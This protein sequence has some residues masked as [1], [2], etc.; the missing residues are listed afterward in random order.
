MSER[1]KMRVYDYVNRPYAEVRSALEADALNVFRNA[2][3]VASHR[4]NTLA[5]ELHVNI[6]GIEVG[7]DIK[8]KINSIETLPATA[9]APETTR[10]ELEWEAANM[11]RLFPFMKAELNVYPLTRSETQLDLNGNYQ[12]PLG[13][14]GSVLDAAVGHRIAEATVQQ[15]IKDVAAFLRA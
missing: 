9:T 7:T 5:S 2:T 6:A 8:I 10:I 13:V 4:A 15:F 11:P 12:P 14:V 3:K 1:N